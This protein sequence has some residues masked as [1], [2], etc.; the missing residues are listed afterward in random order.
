MWENK[1]SITGTSR[2]KDNH[3][4]QTEP[5]SHWISHREG[6]NELHHQTSLPLSVWD[7]SG[8]YMYVPG[9]WDSHGKGVTSPPRPLSNR[10]QQTSKISR[11]T[12]S[13]Q[14]R[15]CLEAS[16]GEPSRWSPTDK[17]LV[18]LKQKSHGHRA[19]LPSGGRTSAS[20]IRQGIQKG[21]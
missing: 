11:Q 6:A 4:H 14:T 18:L 19:W 3:L 10:T 12:S 1:E 8:S 15:Q 5:S 16:L 13:L 9:N 7:L 17:R 2:R 20:S 21:Y